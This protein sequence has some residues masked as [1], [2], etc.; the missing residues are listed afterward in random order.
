MARYIED[1]RIKAGEAELVV[2]VTDK[3]IRRMMEYRNCAAIYTRVR[4]DHYLISIL[5]IPCFV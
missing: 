3:K 1:N 5:F 4:V 2:V